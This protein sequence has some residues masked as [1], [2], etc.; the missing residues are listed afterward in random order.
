[1]KKKRIMLSAALLAMVSLYA[2]KKEVIVEQP[3][4]PVAEVVTPTTESE[5]PVLEPA[6]EA[7]TSTE[8]VTTVTDQQMKD[9]P[10]KANS[11]LQSYYK[12]IAVA[13]YEVK[14]KPGLGKKYEVKL[15]NGVEVEFTD[16]GDW[17]EIKDP[18]GVP[19]ALVPA[20]VKSYVDTNYKGIVI[21]KIDKEKNKIKVDLMNG[22]DL[23][24]DANGKF[25]KID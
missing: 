24:F 19:A 25:V 17:E 22:I 3:Q 10:K 18:N 23:E 4:A 5:A 8:G 15:N 12:G 21:K 13:K 20:S 1:M 16:S 9:L 14:T 7:T 6:P 11:F 2:C